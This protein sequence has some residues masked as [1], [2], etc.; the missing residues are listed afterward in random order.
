MAQAVTA[1]R[2]PRSFSCEALAA[3]QLQVGLVDEA[4]G[5]QRVAARAPPEM[6]ARDPPQLVVHEGHD[7]VEGAPLPRLVGAQE[8]RDL[9]DPAH[10]GDGSTGAARLSRMAASVLADSAR[11]GR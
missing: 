11:E 4:R 6:A 2:W 8:L 10:P 7:P 9:A 3:R 1:I 5:V